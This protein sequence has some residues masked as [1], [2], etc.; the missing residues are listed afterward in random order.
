MS[1]QVR[2]PNPECLR[3]SRLGAD[4]LGRIFRCPRCQTRF[5]RVVAADRHGWSEGPELP[6]S[7]NGT[8]R[9]PVVQAQE[10]VADSWDDGLVPP[11]RAPDP[12]TLDRVGRFR[13]HE[14]LGT[15]AFATV[16]RAFDPLL[17]HDVALKVLRPDFPAVPRALG[18]FRHE[19]RILARL[20][21]PRIVPL[22]EAGHD[23]VL[24]YMSSAYITG[25]TLARALEEGPLDPLVAARVAA[26]MAEALAHAHSR[27]VVHRDVKPANILLDTR[28]EA[29]LMDFGL[30]HRR[31]GEDPS[32]SCSDDVIVGTPAYMAPEQARSGAAMPLPANDQYSLGVVL[33]E[34]LCGQPPFSGPPPLMLFQTI[35][36]DP[37]RPRVLRP[38]IPRELE[39]ICLKALAKRPEDR[40]ASCR[41]LAEELERQAFFP[42]IETGRGVGSGLELQRA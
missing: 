30:A 26:E 19:A 11:R 24:H 33:Y 29:H 22:F 8:L 12:P 32:I 9:R 14:T 37:T 21:H 18:R 13:L 23:G 42:P 4:E 40:F 31:D 27:G 39:A 5:P 25:R 20:R 35:H 38:E 2:C 41:A 36:Q 6:R 17:G 10:R 7:G 1:M 15:G 3:P 34:A 28:G 16:Y